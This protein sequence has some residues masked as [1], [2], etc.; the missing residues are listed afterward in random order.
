M[1]SHIYTYYPGHGQP[2]IDLVI[3]YRWDRAT[4]EVHATAYEGNTLVDEQRFSSPLMVERLLF[5]GL[6]DRKDVTP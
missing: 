2:P 4:R 6:L 3:T 5:A 1:S